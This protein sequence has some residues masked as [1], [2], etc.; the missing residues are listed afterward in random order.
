MYQPQ[1]WAWVASLN[2][3]QSWLT[4]PMKIVMRDPWVGPKNQV[5]E[6]LSQVEEMKEDQFDKNKLFPNE[7]EQ[8]EKTL[9]EV[10]LQY[11]EFCMEE[12]HYE[13]QEKKRK[14]RKE[15]GP[16]ELGEEG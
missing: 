3:F 8:K 2:Q 4:I 15:E 6:I 7:H 9:L 13:A 11:S 12:V 14:G 10:S 16:K 5:K 1:W